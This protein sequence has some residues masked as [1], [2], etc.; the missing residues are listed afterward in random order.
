MFSIVSQ[1][2]NMGGM[3]SQ[4]TQ[5]WGGYKQN[6]PEKKCIVSAVVGVVNMCMSLHRGISDVVAFFERLFPEM[7]AVV[8]IFAPLLKYVPPRPVSF[9]VGGPFRRIVSRRRFKRVDTLLIKSVGWCLFCRSVLVSPV[10]IRM[11]L[12]RA[13]KQTGEQK[14]L[15]YD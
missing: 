11:R 13:T 2:K 1:S 10:L 4:T 6:T 14:P 8:G 15:P 3:S 5:M 12:N 9:G 7:I